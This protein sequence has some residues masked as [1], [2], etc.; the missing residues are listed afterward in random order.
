MIRAAGCFPTL[1]TIMNV[2]GLY[3]KTD[4]PSAGDYVTIRLISFPLGKI[5]QW[6]LVL[7]GFSSLSR[8]VGAR[9]N[10]TS[11]PHLLRFKTTQQESSKYKL[12]RWYH[13]AIII[14]VATS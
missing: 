2:F 5:D 14:D 1:L 9:G 7:V 11:L 10:K 8:R 3:L 12:L 4:I 13:Q 6:T